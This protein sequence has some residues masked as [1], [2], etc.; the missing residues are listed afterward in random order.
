MINKIQHFIEEN[1]LCN[2]GTPI[3]IACSGGVDSMV[4][5]EVLVNL[6]YKI[7]VA[8]CNFNLRGAE[9]DGDAVFV[10]QY[11]LNNKIDFYYKKF[12]TKK[13][14]QEQKISTQ[15]V[16][17]TLRYE[18]FEQIRKEN[19]FH[20]IATAHHLDDQ[21]ETILLNFTKGT[22]VNG[23]K[24]MLPK[25]NF[26]IRPMLAVSKLDILQ[27]ATEK[28]IEYRTDSSNDSKDYLRNKIRHDVVPILSEINPSLIQN[29]NSFSNY[30]IDAQILI[31][32]QIKAIKKK[33]WSEK[34]GTILIYMN[35]IKT[36]RAKYTILYYLLKDFGFTQDSLLNILESKHVST[37]FFSPTHRLIVDRNKLIVSYIHQEKNE[38]L[39]FDKIPNQIIFNDIKIQCKIVP[40]EKLNIKYINN[41][42]Y[43]DVAKISLPL[44][45]RFLNEGDYFYPFG[46]GKSK[47]ASKI[48]KKKVSKY[49]RDEKLNLLE[50]ENTAIIF[51]DE[52]VVWL[53][54]HRIDDRFKITAQTTKVL[55]LKLIK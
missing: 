40:I 1:N 48:G 45:I 27:F 7:A 36:H 21:L 13:Y 28:N 15:M 20:F 49:F 39:L 23:L 37:Q 10:E 43:I 11:C 8:H 19:G 29:I 47:N 16:A 5:L 22:G 50:K 25:N 44:K 42:A 46:L 33:C 24:G 18:W 9:S 30:M 2:S 51:S 3:L 41:Y 35:Y 26:I 55:K 17:R 14:K 34:N 53:V 38:I 12:D 31:E 32:A 6:K 54:G 4:L 52:K